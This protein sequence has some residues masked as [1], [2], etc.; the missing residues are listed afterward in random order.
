M[1]GRLKL[2]DL[3]EMAGAGDDH[4]KSAGFTRTRISWFSLLREGGHGSEW[5][6]AKDIGEE[7]EEWRKDEE[8]YKPDQ[9]T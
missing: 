3:G 8:R 2:C 7:R 4:V 1:R 5:V 6:A 9:N